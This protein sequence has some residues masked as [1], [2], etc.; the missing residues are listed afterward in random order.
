MT[1]TADT[2][3]VKKTASIFDIC[4]TD[5]TAEENGRWFKD[6]YGDGTNIDVKL[7]HLSSSESMSV[8]RRL[9]RANR[10]LMVKGE[11]PTSVAIQL[12]I[13]QI[14]EA[15]LIDWRGVLDKDGS[16]IPY[17][18]ETAVMLM[19][20]LRTFRDGIVAMCQSIDNFRIEDR[21]DAEKN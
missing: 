9:D 12:L 7:R 8:R 3:K 13:E 16:E 5:T 15:V 21:A 2:V 10:R 11:Y 14:A 19:T 1:E 18:K 17:S 6:I 4:E 20:K